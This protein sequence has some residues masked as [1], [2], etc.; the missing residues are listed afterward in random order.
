MFKKFHFAVV[1]RLLCVRQAALVSFE[2]AED[3][4]QDNMSGLAAQM[5]RLN[6]NSSSSKVGSSAVDHQ[7][8]LS[9]IL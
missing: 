9:C 3:K 7:P 6:L 4:K 8:L 2:Q 1:K 5:N